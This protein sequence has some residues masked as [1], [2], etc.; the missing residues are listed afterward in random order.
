[1]DR[2]GKLNLQGPSFVRYYPGSQGN[3]TST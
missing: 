3:T 2:V 1:L